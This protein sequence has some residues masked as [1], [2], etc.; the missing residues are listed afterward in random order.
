MES[1][2]DKIALELGWSKPNEE[3]PLWFREH[4]KGLLKAVF[5]I[6]NNYDIFKNHEKIDNDFVN[7]SLNFCPSSIFKKENE[8]WCIPLLSSDY[9]AHKNDFENELFWAKKAME[10]NENLTPLQF[11]KQIRHRL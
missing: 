8:N 4:K 10:Q 7:H 11:S 2:F 9:F 3:V 1:K 6:N 5:D